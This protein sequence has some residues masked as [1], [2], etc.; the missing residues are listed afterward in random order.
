MSSLFKP[1]EVHI[2]ES[3]AISYIQQAQEQTKKPLCYSPCYGDLIKI[4]CYVRVI[5][6]LPGIYG[7]ILTES[8]GVARGQGQF[9]LP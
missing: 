9:M 1:S 7:S 6:Q 5:A 2:Y 3:R 4:T 8:E